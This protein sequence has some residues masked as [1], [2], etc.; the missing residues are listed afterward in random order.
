MPAFKS[1]Q[2]TCNERDPKPDFGLFVLSIMM[3]GDD[4]SIATT[5]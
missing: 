4:I 2:S 1:H 3:D 5:V